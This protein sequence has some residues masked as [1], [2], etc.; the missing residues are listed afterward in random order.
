MHPNN[1]YQ[2][3]GVSPDAED[4]VIR[5]AYKALVQRY[6]PDKYQDPKNEEIKKIQ[7]INEAY[8]VLSDKLKRQEYDASYQAESQKQPNQNQSTKSETDRAWEIAVE[9]HPEL[10]D[11]VFRLTNFS[12]PL[13]AEFKES[14][15]N[16]KRFNEAR[17][18]A[19]DAEQ[20]F[21]V[22]HYGEDSRVVEFARQLFLRGKLEAAREFN[23]VLIVM[24]KSVDLQEVIDRIAKKHLPNY[25][26][27]DAK[28][29]KA[30]QNVSKK[31]MSK[32]EGNIQGYIRFDEYINKYNVSKKIIKKWIATGN[33]KSK[34][35]DEKNIKEVLY[36]E[37]VKPIKKTT[38]SLSFEIT[39]LAVLI[40]FLVL[41]VVIK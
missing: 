29:E 3:L 18:L 19:L 23:E 21:L 2:I 38:A 15:L 14:L 27:R 7:L 5:A 24:D 31:E 11:I 1:Y 28:K 40:I 30:D 8:Q 4:F 20:K 22:D 39:V 37:D 34:L 25:S 33:I 13:A 12:Q 9:Y 36:L 26:R 6:H 17:E 10:F 35:I 41:L 32:T 16:S